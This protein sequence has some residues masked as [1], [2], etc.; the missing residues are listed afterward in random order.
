MVSQLIRL[1]RR[2]GRG[3]DGIDHPPGG[4][5]DLINAAAGAVVMAQGDLGPFLPGDVEDYLVD[6]GHVGIDLLLRTI[7]G[8][9]GELM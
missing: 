4:H 1:E 7:P 2:T 3:R 5:D 6:V 9:P 8:D